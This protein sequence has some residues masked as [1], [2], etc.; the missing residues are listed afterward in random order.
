[1]TRWDIV[2]RKIEEHRTGPVACGLRHIAEQLAIRELFGPRARLVRTGDNG[3]DTSWDGRGTSVTPTQWRDAI[4][5]Q[6]G[7]PSELHR[8]V[9]FDD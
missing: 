3:V 6:H 4:V 7:G 2:N 1:M 5:L 8:V 9:V